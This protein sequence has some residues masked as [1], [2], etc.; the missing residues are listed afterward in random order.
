V[1][2]AKEDGDFSFVKYLTGIC[3]DPGPDDP[4]P[5]FARVADMNGDACPDIVAS[6]TLSDNIGVAFYH[7]NEIDAPG[8]E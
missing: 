4:K 2:L 6:C 7:C 3:V 5:C 8:G 1:L